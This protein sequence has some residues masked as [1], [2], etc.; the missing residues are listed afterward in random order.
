MGR[1]K[2]TRALAVLVTLAVLPTLAA[3][4]EIAQRKEAAVRTALEKQGKTGDFASLI[5]STARASAI[6]DVKMG[7]TP[8]SPEVTIQAEGRPSYEWFKL[9]GGK[10]I[11]VD[12]H[13][14]IHLQSGLKLAP[15]GAAPLLR[16]RSSLFAMEPEFVSR[17]VI[18]LQTPAQP[19]FSQ[20]D[21]VV[22]IRLRKSAA[23]EAAA[24]LSEKAMQLASKVEQAVQQIES[25][26]QRLNEIIQRASLEDAPE[27]LANDEIR[28]LV[29][30]A[31]DTDRKTIE[32][33]DGVAA[34]ARKPLGVQ[35][36]R[37]DEL[38]AAL[39]ARTIETAKAK[40][41]LQSIDRE[42]STASAQAE[43]G[44]S[45]IEKGL[46]ASFEKRAKNYETLIAK[47]REAH[48][49]AAEA[50]KAALAKAEAEKSTLA[51]EPPAVVPPTP[52]AIPSD[53]PEAPIEQPRRIERVESTIEKIER[54]LASMRAA[55]SVTAEPVIVAPAPAAPS[56]QATLARLETLTSDMQRL[57]AKVSA[58]TPSAAIDADTGMQTTTAV[59]VNLVPN[60][61]PLDAAPARTSQTQNTTGPDILAA[62]AASPES[63][64]EEKEEEKPASEPSA[65]ETPAVPAQGAET[66]AQ[67]PLP[68]QAQNVKTVEEPAAVEAPKEPAQ[69]PKIIAAPKPAEREALPPGVDPLDQI[70]NIDFREMDLSSVVSLLAKKGQVNVIAG[71]EV[72]GTVTADIRNVPLRKAMD[73]VL[74]M[75][76]LGIVEEEG[77]F[78]IVPYEEA[79]AARRSTKM[80]ALDNAQADDVRTT[81]E[82]ILVGGRDA[83]IISVSANKNTNTLIISG[84]ED[85]AAELE[86]LAR[87]LDV[88]K[89]TLPTVTEAIKL[90]YLDPKS[91]KPIAETMKTDKIGKVEVD[92]EGR[93]LV[94]TDIPAAVEQM[95]ALLLTVDKPVKQVAIEA[96]IVDAV[97]S[98]ASQT[99]V[100]WTIE[101]LRRH[102]T[103]G[104]LVSDLSQLRMDANL[105]QIGT[106]ALD[107]GIISLGTLSSEVRLNATIAAEVQSRNAQILASP[108]IVTVENQP[109][110]I[111]I[112]QE[113]PY[114]EITQGLTGPPV[115]STSFKPIG[116]TLEVTP[117]ITHSNDT[118]VE[119]QA[120]QSSVSGLT[121]S[122]VPIE[123]KR[124]AH[125][126]LRAQDGRT[127]FIGGLRNTSDRLNVSK[128]PVLGDIPVLNFMFRNTNAQKQNT[129][130]LIFLTCRVMDQELPDLTATQQESFDK[131]DATPKVPD[132]QRAMFHDQLRP[133]DMRDPMWKWRRSN[134]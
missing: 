109:A 37:L 80:I 86:R 21:G 45:A 126:T 88:K 49:K 73:M 44:F 128:I 102:S 93:H 127:I 27:E 68:D 17:V 33:V 1:L 19:E 66:S 15:I 69:P 72:S 120:K 47:S 14:T 111:S 79:V 115:A 7:G 70:V 3:G 108:S 96:M 42:I 84:P 123:D 65:P 83:K 113:F 90:N 30:N 107:A 105:G 51:S 67:A 25:Q 62:Q 87:E 121:E 76:G 5:E 116:V 6:L 77:I 4:E 50:E 60:M 52:V 24:T 118:I 99:G 71:T 103:N 38:Q 131:L 106:E 10:R 54:D 2:C 74:R 58:E 34:L 40:T 23:D 16:V 94:V 56:P 133:Q 82:G 78:R 46:A 26:R 104:D 92:Q 117:R 101:A 29:S 132:G 124:E 130:L 114:Q 91:A 12:F 28:S 129:E 134:R 63:G 100:D 97:L 18:D 35:R 39:Y 75:N 43:K 55:N 98:D 81:L 8:G 85:R 122:G 59:A 48:E 89:P 32:R 53:A 22:T 9:D 95:K 64:P 112:V 61:G 57:A 119:I 20:E 31:A 13:N 41:V 125:T 110:T 11:V 36:G